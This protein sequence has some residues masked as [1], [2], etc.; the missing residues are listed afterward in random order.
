MMT[1]YVQATRERDL[2]EMCRRKKKSV[3]RMEIRFGHKFSSP[4]AN[5]DRR[6]QFHQ[7]FC[8]KCKYMFG[9]KVLFIFTNTIKPQLY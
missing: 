2:N 6:C 9:V 7:P 5:I 4:N 1:L 3:K 8:T